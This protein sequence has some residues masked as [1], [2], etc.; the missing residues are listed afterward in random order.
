MRAG[1]RRGACEVPR[2]QARVVLVVLVVLA[3]TAG[4]SIRRQ[5]RCRRRRCMC[6]AASDSRSHQRHPMAAAQASAAA[7]HSRLGSA[8]GSIA[9]C[10]RRHATCNRRHATCIRQHAT[11]NRQHATCIRQ[12]GMCGRGVGAVL[13]RHA[14]VS[15]RQCREVQRS[16]VQRS[17]MLCSPAA[18]LPLTRPTLIVV[19]EAD[20]VRQ[21][22]YNGHLYPYNGHSYCHNG[23][24]Y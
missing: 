19:G 18:R 10:N 14:V 24:S 11:C 9:T 7:P 6:A 8:P 4:P 16:A 1:Q 15:N 3:S 21:S 13:H 22:P 2:G 12:H 5:C 23:H 20:K 17:G